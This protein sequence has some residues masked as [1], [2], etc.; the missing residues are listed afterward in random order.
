MTKKRNIIWLSELSKKDA[1]IAGSKA[2]NLGELYNLNF[3][4]PQAFVITTQAFNTFIEKTKDQIKEILKKINIED[5]K[6]LE[7][8]SREI[9]SII[10]NSEMLP[11]LRKEILE[12]YDHFNVDLEGL[13]SSPDAMAIMKS[14]REPIFVSVRSSASAE[15]LSDTS[16]TGQLDSF[17]NIKGNNELIEY[18][19]KVF[20]SIFTA[21]AIYYIRK[22]GFDDFVSPSVIVQKMISSDKA[23]AIFSQD[24]RTQEGILI[25]AVY[26]Q[27]KGLISGKI[28]PD[29][30]KLSDE[31]EILKEK[32]S[33]KKIAITRDGAGLTKTV[34]LTPER[35]NQRT[36]K[37]HEIKQLAEYAK[38][39]EQHYE[40]PQD[41]EFAI[42]ND[43]IFILQTR[44]ITTSKKQEQEKLDGNLLTQGLPASSEIVSGNVKII[45]STKDLEKVKQGD[46]IVT[47]RTTPEMILTMQKAAGIITD[48]GGTTSHIA[49][50]SREI[51]IPAIVGTENSTSILRDCQEIT[52][53][54]FT[55]KIFE[56]KAKNQELEI[57]P[58]LQT[59]TKVKTII[60]LPKFAERASKTNS[61]GVGLIELEGII[62]SSEKHPLYY[63]QNNCLEEYTK[64]I[65]RGLL[66]IA[67]L[68][69]G[70]EIWVR[71]PDIKSDKSSKLECS[72]ESEKNPLLGLHGIRF[73]LKHRD[74]FKAEL[75]AIKN[76]ADKG[77][78]FG[79]MLPQVISPEEIKQAK[80]ILQ[81]MQMLGNENIKIGATVETPAA[82][83]LIKDICQEGLDFISIRTDD[84]TQYTLAVDKENEETQHLYNDLDW[85][86]K[87]QV[88]RVIRECKKNNIK[89]SICGGASSKK[90]MVEFLV[91][92]GIDSISVNSDSAYEISKIIYNLENSNETNQQQEKPIQN[93]I[94]EKQ[95]QQ[96]NQKQEQKTQEIN[97]TNNPQQENKPFS[98]F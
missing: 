86:I 56:G 26:G 34:Q 16:F 28:K 60:E 69:I 5:T 32:I 89:T 90:E 83:I 71:T 25:E 31:L 45:L 76:L 23:G 43:K 79:I 4:V 2:A 51:G 15:D 68:F 93:N 30:Y 33:D 73:S 20:A 44:A 62:A 59:K 61:D 40:K 24:P 11:E 64:L 21:R 9:R 18:V 75:Q 97:Q 39:I 52:I 53:D 66:Q 96:T 85:A 55:G 98:I 8:K 95:I 65:E 10:I 6:D 74:I 29:Q 47:T 78:K 94:Q 27:G 77:H 36:L 12:A 92:A 67:E 13:K 49:I 58:V 1:K 70:K 81:Q 19:K 46:I 42:E 82:T 80:S 72:K 41:I 14:A 22:K 38:K 88:S 57:K 17:I 87:K 48:E 7:E 84:L 3:P 50:L 91:K 54:G 63:K 37:T 35:S